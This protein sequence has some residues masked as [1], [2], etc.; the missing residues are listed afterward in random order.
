VNPCCQLPNPELWI[1]FSAAAA[2]YLV[3]ISSQLFCQL[4]TPET[5]LS[6]TADSQ[7]T[8]GLGSSLYS[9]E[10][11][12]TEKAASIIIFQQY[13]DCC[14]HI[15]CRGNVFTEPLLSNE[16][17]L[18]L[19]YPAFRSYTLMP[20]SALQID[21]CLYICVPTPCLL[22]NILSLYYV[23]RTTCFGLTGHHQVYKVLDW[24]NSPLCYYA[25]L[26]LILM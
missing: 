12:P 22:C 13:F 9:L 15:I 20:F 24:R 10:V 11:G 5:Q 6:S 7:L 18:W 3:T 2:N 25:V 1:Q 8:V 4:P 16:R 17:L 14:L 23:Y 26:L 19:H 21:T